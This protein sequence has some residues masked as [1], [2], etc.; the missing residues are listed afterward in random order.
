MSNVQSTPKKEQAQVLPNPQSSAS[1]T[2]VIIHPSLEE[3]KPLKS[4]SDVAKSVINLSSLLKQ[5]ENFQVRLS[6]IHDFKQLL[7]D[8]SGCT[9]KITHA[10]GKEISFQNVD[11]I[12]KFIIEAFEGGEIALVELEQKITNHTL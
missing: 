2:D 6:E 5:H 7:I 9:M 10:S 3:I 8:G 12:K 4:V 11:S 1:K